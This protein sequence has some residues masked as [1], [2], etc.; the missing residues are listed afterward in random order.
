MQVGIEGLT[1]LCVRVIRAFRFTSTNSVMPAMLG[2]LLVADFWRERL[3]WKIAGTVE[4][5]R[6]RHN[7]S[8]PYASALRVI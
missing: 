3:G 6:G 8:I 5:C 4:S 2:S 7:P 1:A